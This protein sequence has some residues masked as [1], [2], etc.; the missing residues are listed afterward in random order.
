[1][2]VF[3][4][5]SKL[6][7]SHPGPPPTQADVVVIGA[8][9]I[10]VMTAWYLARRGFS[11]VICEKGRV[12][13]EQSSRNWGWIRQQGRDP[14]ELP[15]MMEATR[16]WPELEAECGEDIGY[17]R[18]GVLYLAGSESEMAA[19]E[20]WLET[21]QAHDLETRLVG[22]AE[23]ARM[24]PQAAALWKGGLHTPGDACAEPW[25]AVPALARAAARR[26]VPIVE[27]CAVRGLDLRAGRVA[28]VVT[29]QGRI[30]CDH[31]V[32][33]GGAWSA[34]F[35][36]NLGVMLPQLSVLATAAATAALPRVFDGAAAE[37]RFALRRRQDGGYTIAPGGVHDLLLG[38][39]AFR[40]FTRYMPQLRSDPLATRLK[41][42]APRGYPDGWRTP[43]G[44]NLDARSPFEDMRVLN[45]DPNRR[46]LARIVERFAEV[47]PTL[48]R[49][50]L[51]MAWG[52]MIDTMPDLLPVIDRVHQVPG[53]VVATGMSGH[54]FGI[55][56]AIGR[57]VAEMV[58]GN[59]VGHDLH[60]FRLSRFFDGSRIV[61]SPA[62]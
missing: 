28:A 17:R 6:P 44:W 33:A 55:G 37:A 56:P 8:G 41:P 16:L 50:G 3:P 19:Y 13:A 12:A 39:D 36:R 7:V 38:P 31:V 49:P 46:S 10:G 47:F 35:L 9:I 57:V 2:S 21:A 48:G 62:I 30:A 40:H 25:L 15:I 24:M 59:P 61:P 60:R 42:F 29:E 32:L 1:M 51:R 58:A 22:R 18:C 4:F 11:V 5:S 14:H 54:G 52:G 26:G 23:I 27:N 20:H 45:P 34:L 53:L 43:R